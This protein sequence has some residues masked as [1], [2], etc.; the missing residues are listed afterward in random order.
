MSKIVIAKTKDMNREEWLAL[1]KKGIG[2]SD[3]AAVCGMSR[4]KGPLDVYLDKT[5]PVIEE[6]DNEPMLFG[7]LFEP[8]LRSEF[9]RCRVSLYVRLLSGTIVHNR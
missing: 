2:G 3:A 9:A 6:N 7:R 8:I 4:Y 1:R 5:N